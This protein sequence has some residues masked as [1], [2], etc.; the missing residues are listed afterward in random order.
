MSLTIFKSMPSAPDFRRRKG[1][2]D[3]KLHFTLCYAYHVLGAFLNIVDTQSYISFRCTTQ[4]FD[5][6]L[7]YVMPTT[8]VPAICHHTMTLLRYH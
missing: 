3:I 1:I 4:G 7:H 5:F 6:C 2:Y 8:R